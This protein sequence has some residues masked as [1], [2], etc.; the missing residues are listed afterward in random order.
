MNIMTEG[1]VDFSNYNTMTIKAKIITDDS[2]KRGFGVYGC[3]SSHYDLDNCT[4][5]VT[6]GAYNTYHASE[7]E[8]TMT[9]DISSI[10]TSYYLRL[11]AVLCNIRIYEILLS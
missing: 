4:I 5:A 6:I 9:F 10:N 3:S 2:S 8:V 1:K 11:Q 7:S